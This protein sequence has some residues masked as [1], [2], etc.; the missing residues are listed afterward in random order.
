MKAEDDSTTINIDGK[1]YLAEMNSF[2]IKGSI[3]SYYYRSDNASMR[4]ALGAATSNEFQVP[5]GWRQNFQNG[6]I[7]HSGAGSYTIRGSVG[8]YYLSLGAEKSLLGLPTSNEFQVP[9]GWRQNFEGGAI[10]HSGAGSYTVRGSLG[11]YY[12][13]NLG[14]EKSQLGLPTGNEVQVSD[15]WRQNFER[16]SVNWLHTGRGTFTLNSSPTDAF[17]LLNDPNLIVLVCIVLCNTKFHILTNA[18]MLLPKVVKE[19]VT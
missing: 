15:G 11:N 5:N 4:T 10:F 2:A 13:N 7:F 16:G 1:Q 18:I 12:L 6:A 19:S 8:N 14:G 17:A 9:N 3:G